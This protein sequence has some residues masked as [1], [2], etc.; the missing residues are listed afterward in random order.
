MSSNYS[1]YPVTIIFS[2]ILIFLSLQSCVSQHRKFRKMA[3]DAFEA[4]RYDESVKQAVNSLF[5]KPEKNTKA[6]EVLELAYPRFI[7]DY[8]DKIK[9]LQAQSSSFSDDKTVKE[10]REIVSRYETLINYINDIKNLPPAAFKMKRR[11]IAFQYND[12]YNQLTEAKNNLERGIE[13]AAE[14]HY[15]KGLSL[16]AS[17]GIP[18]NKE[19]AKEFK[20]ALGYVPNY[21]DATDKYNEARKAGTTRIAIIP[22]DNKSGRTHYG[23]IGEMITDKV[24][25]IMFEDQTAMEFLEIVDRE[26]LEVV[27]KE[28]KLSLSGAV[29]DN[30]LVEVGKILGVQEMITGR[31]TQI[32]SDKEDINKESKPIKR[33]IKVKTGEKTNSEGKKEAV[34]G[35]REVSAV[36]TQ[37]S[38]TAGA[39]MSGS[40]KILEVKTA[41]LIE[42]KSFDES[43]SFYHEWATFRG[44]E[45]AL[46]SS[47][48]RLVSVKEKNALSDGE[49]V[50]AV[51]NKL[52]KALAT[53]IK[54]YTR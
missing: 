3:E 26:Q 9:R 52:A 17:G 47:E 27:M 19:G 23:A 54:E 25:S 45:R 30:T 34:Y 31:I 5:E 13:D 35:D 36:I 21:R 8:E 41:R 12:Y 29:D 20:K 46:N 42:T 22:F 10:R 11:T 39:K 53:K 18:N 28:Q 16:M 32:I 48:K 1:R 40:Y 24:V 4:R 7:N 44:D 38:K 43:Y 49:R 2:F 51:G 33:T 37:F 6:Q 14:L 50:N 15:Q